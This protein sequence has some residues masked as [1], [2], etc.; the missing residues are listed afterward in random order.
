[1][2]NYVAEFLVLG[3]EVD[4]FGAVGWRE[5][6]DEVDEVDEVDARDCSD[7][8]LVGGGVGGGVCGGGG[9]RPTFPWL[10]TASKVS[11]VTAPRVA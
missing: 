9:D 4:W 1:M 10:S 6:D 5:E 7:D 3:A 11:T 8:D 2:E